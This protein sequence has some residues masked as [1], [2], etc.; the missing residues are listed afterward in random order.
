MDNNLIDLSALENALSELGDINY[1][2]EMMTE[3]MKASE[4]RCSQYIEKHMEA[5][6]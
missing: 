4:Q 2:E 6:M 1:G 5:D 3:E